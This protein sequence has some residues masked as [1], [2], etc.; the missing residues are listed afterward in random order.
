VSGVPAAAAHKL[1]AE[2]LRNRRV[3]EVTGRPGRNDPRP[4][5]RRGGDGEKGR[6]I[7][8]RDCVGSGGRGG[9]GKGEIGGRAGREAVWAIQVTVREGKEREEFEG[10]RNGRSLKG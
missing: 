5:P 1:R 7:A 3:R 9:G 4:R 2:E 6:K 10:E 8:S